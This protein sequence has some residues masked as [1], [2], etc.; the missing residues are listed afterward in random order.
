LNTNYKEKIEEEAKDKQKMMEQYI[1][2]YKKIPIDKRTDAELKKYNNY[3]VTLNKNKN[4]DEPK[5]SKYDEEKYQTMKQYIED[6][7]SKP[8]SERTDDETKKYNT[9]RVLLN[10]NYKDVDFDKPV[11]KSKDDDSVGDSDSSVGDSDSSVDRDMEDNFVRELSKI[12]IEERDPE[13]QQLYEKI[14][15]SRGKK[16]ICKGKKRD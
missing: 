11:S 5:I 7:K 16:I 6:Y 13:E 1:E 9:Y 10:R 8:K 12:P 2:E 15:K 3:R 4:K 14:V